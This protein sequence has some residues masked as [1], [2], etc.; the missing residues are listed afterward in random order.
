MKSKDKIL[1]FN[2]NV[3]FLGLASLFT[4]ISSEM[5]YPLIPIFLT[6]VLGAPV[7]IVGLIEGVAESTASIIKGF[8]GWL[9]DRMRKRK[10]L[11]VA[12]Y[13]LSALA[14]PLI[15]ASL[16]WW[17]VLAARFSDRFGKGI[18]TSPRDALLADSSSKKE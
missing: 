12:G 17:Q 6:S 7:A 8:S 13:S 9:S 5:I 14:K 18:R 10:K 16:N 3:F 1:G 15:A 2:K 11:I 4:D